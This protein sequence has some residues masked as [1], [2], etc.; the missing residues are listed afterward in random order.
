MLDNKSRPN[1]TTRCRQHGGRKFILLARYRLSRIPQMPDSN[2][3]RPPVPNCFPNRSRNVEST[4][5]FYLRCNVN[6]NSQYADFHE[7][8]PPSTTVCEDLLH[9]ISWKSD[10]RLRRCNR[11]KT[12]TAGRSGGR[13]LHQ[14]PLSIFRKQRLEKHRDATQQKLRQY[15]IIRTVSIIEEMGCKQNVRTTARH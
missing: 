13:R 11:S 4:G 8:P 14:V 15:K 6:H 1:R 12:N 2:I 10:K 5:R 3:L 7:P 9:R